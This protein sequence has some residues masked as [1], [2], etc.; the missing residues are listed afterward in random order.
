MALV[1]RTLTV[2]CPCVGTPH[3]ADTVQFRRVL[4]LAGG[5][6]AIAAMRDS[7][8]K[9]PKG[10]EVLDPLVLAEYLFPV[11]LVHAVESWT[12]VD[13]QGTPLPLAGADEALPFDTKYDIADAADDLFGEEVTRPL[14]GMIQRSLRAGRTRRSTSPKKRSGRSP[15]SPSAP[16]SPGITA[17]TRQPIA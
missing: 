7:A 1:G 3:E 15:R 12:F 4:P 14:A 10:A 13:E 9:A 2:E 11:Y 5:M 16:S 17:D 8:T 6:A